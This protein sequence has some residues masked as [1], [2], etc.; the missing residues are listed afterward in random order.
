MCV[1]CYSSYISGIGQMAKQGRPTG[2]TEEMKAMLCDNV[3]TKFVFDDGSCNTFHFLMTLI[4]SFL[5]PLHMTLFFL[6]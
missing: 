6:N 4:H 2:K 3:L 1:K 5:T